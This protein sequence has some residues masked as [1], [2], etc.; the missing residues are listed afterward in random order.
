MAFCSRHIPVGVFQWLTGD[1]RQR[2]IPLQKYLLGTYAKSS[3]APAS[4]SP[5]DPAPAAQRL[6]AQDQVRPVKLG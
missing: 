4:P 6:K 3:R 1:Q 2:R 5:W